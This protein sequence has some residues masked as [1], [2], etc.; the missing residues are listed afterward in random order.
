MANQLPNSLYMFIA[1]KTLPIRQRFN[2]ILMLLLYV[3]SAAFYSELSLSFS[4]YRMYVI[5][6]ALP[7]MHTPEY[8]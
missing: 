2:V 5:V 7:K 3:D 1:Y 8:W 4:F 6:Q